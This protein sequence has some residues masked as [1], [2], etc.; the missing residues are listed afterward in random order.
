MAHG[1]PSGLHFRQQVGT[2]Q[3]ATYWINIER[4]TPKPLAHARAPVVNLPTRCYRNKI[5]QMIP[6]M[7]LNGVVH[8]QAHRNLGIN[9]VPRSAN[10]ALKVAPERRQVL[11]QLLAIAAQRL[12]A[13]QTLMRWQIFQGLP[14]PLTTLKGRDARTIDD[15]A[16][17]IITHG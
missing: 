2:T 6:H 7:L 16:R 3:K 15:H 14:A 1:A 4:L 5:T 11:I 13:A 8:A 10:L 17:H 9:L 12:R